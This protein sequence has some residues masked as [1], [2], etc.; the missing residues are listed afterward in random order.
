MPGCADTFF[1]EEANRRRSG[2]CRKTGT[3]GKSRHTR[4]PEAGIG[5]AQ[6][7][8]SDR[9]P[10]SVAFYQ[11]LWRCG[12]IR[13]SRKSKSGEICITWIGHASFLIQLEGMNVLIDPNWSM[14]LKVIKRLK[15]PGMNIDNL[16]SIDT[17]PGD[18]RALRSSRSPRPCAG[19]RPT[20][21]SSCRPGSAIWCTISVST[22]CTSSSEWEQVQLGPL[23]ISLTPCHHWGAR[24]LHDSHRGFGGFVIEANGRSI[25]HCGDSAY[26]SGLQGN[27]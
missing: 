9:G 21:R 14:W 4:R 7:Q 25:F 18:A 27:R 23:K 5:L 11:A 19:S 24:M 20:N 6:A 10:D 26:F 3:G 17:R 1:A 12:P 2:E 13:S 22:S 16:P 15:R 8:L